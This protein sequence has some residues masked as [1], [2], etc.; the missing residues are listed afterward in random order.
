V[1]GEIESDGEEDGVTRDSSA[2]YHLQPH[3]ES[4]PGVTSELYAA[5]TT[6]ASHPN[7][8]RAAD[9]TSQVYVADTYRLQQAAGSEPSVPSVSQAESEGESE[10]KR[11]SLSH[12]GA[13]AG[14]T[15]KVTHTHTNKIAESRETH[16]K[17][18]ESSETLQKSIDSDIL[19]DLPSHVGAAT[20]GAVDPGLV[21]EWGGQGVAKRGVAWVGEGYGSAVEYARK[22]ALQHHAQSEHER[23]R[24]QEREKERERQQHSDMEIES[25]LAKERHR[26]RVRKAEIVRD[27]AHEKECA[28]GMRAQ[29][30]PAPDMQSLRGIDRAHL[31]L[32][33][34]EQSEIEDRE[35]REARVCLRAR[36]EQER[37]QREQRQGEREREEEEKSRQ[38]RQEREWGRGVGAVEN[39]YT[40]LLHLR[41][42]AEGGGGGEEMAGVSAAISG[43]LCCYRIYMYICIY[44]CVHLHSFIYVCTYMH[45]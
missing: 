13:A 45:V 8:V 40:K 5:D 32:H 9:T 44:I 11:E 27:I 42:R 26:Q 6:S 29:D 24:E 28:R 38:A 14:N 1:T 19:Q 31:E 41:G 4:G 25:E 10:R 3:R 33:H 2:Q 35:G 18:F 20:G 21:R 23:V 22:L 43:A 12:V 17:S 39:K 15:C 7:E 34:R 16:Q 37:D 36:E 30:M